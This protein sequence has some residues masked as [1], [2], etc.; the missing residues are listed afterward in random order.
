MVGQSGGLYVK[1]SFERSPER[2]QGERQGRISGKG[3]ASGEKRVHPEP[4]AGTQV[5]AQ[6]GARRWA[7][8]VQSEQMGEPRGWAG[9]KFHR[10]PEGMRGHSN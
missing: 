4:Q 9:G 5:G 6:G 2:R 1:L 7:W 3:L 10:A 8:L